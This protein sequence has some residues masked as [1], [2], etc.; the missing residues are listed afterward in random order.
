MAKPQNE[1]QQPIAM[2]APV[3]MSRADDSGATTS[4]AD[5]NG[6]GYKMA[7]FLPASQFT[8]AADAPKPTS[9]DVKLTDVP[10]RTVAGRVGTFLHFNLHSKHQLR[11]PVYSIH[12][13]NLTPGSEASMSM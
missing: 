3:L 11:Q 13:T 4:S 2:T 5:D 1:G 10:A 6:K 12:V 9:P 7:F 8:R